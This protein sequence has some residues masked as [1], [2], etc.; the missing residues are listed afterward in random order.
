MGLDLL[1]QLALGRD[2][3]LQS[4]FE[5]GFGRGIRSSRKGSIANGNCGN[6]L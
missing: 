1:E 2:G 6:R 4:R 5:V 3:G